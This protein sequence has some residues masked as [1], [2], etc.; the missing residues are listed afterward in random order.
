MRFQ[1]NKMGC[2]PVRFK[3]KC[4]NGLYMY[5]HNCDSELYG[6]WE[7]SYNSSD[8]VRKSIE[9]EQASLGKLENCP[10]CGAEL[11]KDAKFRRLFYR[12]PNMPDVDRAFQHMRND[13]EKQKE[14]TATQQISALCQTMDMP[15]KNEIDNPYTAQIKQDSGKLLTYLNQLIQLESNIYLQT[16]RLVYLYMQRIGNDALALRTTLDHSDCNYSSIKH[17]KLLISRNVFIAVSKS[18]FSSV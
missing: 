10:I 12:T 15:V 11:T 16:K 17:S 6:L 9:K 5:C 1:I 14:Q 3:Q 13:I 18:C 4:W 7:F 8:K 2:E